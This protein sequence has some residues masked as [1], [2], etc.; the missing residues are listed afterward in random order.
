MGF[1]LQGFLL[2]QLPLNSSLKGSPLAVTTV[3]TL[4][5]AGCLGLPLAKAGSTSGVCILSEFVL[6][7]ATRL[8]F[9]PGRSPP[10]FGPP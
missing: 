2:G 10:G 3:A 9:R 6:G 7:A 5:F 8:K 4:A 1:S